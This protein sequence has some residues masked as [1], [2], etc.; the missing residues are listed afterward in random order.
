MLLYIIM[1]SKSKPS[2]RV[3]GAPNTNKE[4][5]LEPHTGK[6]WVVGMPIH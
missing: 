1:K 6:E 5:T 3:I 4:K 2:K